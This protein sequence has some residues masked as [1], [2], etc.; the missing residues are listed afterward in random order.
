LYTK[1]FFHRIET[2]SRGSSACRVLKDHAIEPL[3]Q[4]CAEPFAEQVYG[5]T[6]VDANQLGFSGAHVQAG[7]QGR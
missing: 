6:A 4:T 7:D 2:D 5:W 1:A 3:R